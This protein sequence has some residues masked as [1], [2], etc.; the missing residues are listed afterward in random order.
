LIPITNLDAI[1]SSKT[2]E[3]DTAETFEGKPL[4]NKNDAKQQVTDKDPDS[5]LSA[6]DFA[7]SASEILAHWAELRL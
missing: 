6:K 5:H 2:K 3:E 7:D 4:D 1:E